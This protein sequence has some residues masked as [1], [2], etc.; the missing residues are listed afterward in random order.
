VS[1]QTGALQYSYRIKVPPGRNGVA[2]SLALTYSSQAPIYGGIAAG[3]SLPLGLI[4]DDTSRAW[5]PT[6]SPQYG[7]NPDD[8]RFVVNESRLVAVDEP[9]AADVYKTY[10][11]ANGDTSYTRYERLVAGAGA[12]WRAR[13]HDGSTTFYGEAY[14]PLTSLP[15]ASACSNVGDGYAPITRS[16]DPFGNEI[17]YRWESTISGE[18]RIME[19][20]W[21]QNANAAMNAFAKVAFSYDST[22]A[23][24]ASDLFIGGQVDYRSGKRIV[25]GASRL[26]SITAT[27][28]NP[29]TPSTPDHTRTITLGYSATPCNA[30]Y[31]PVRLLT[32]IQETAVGTD[33]PQVALPA[34]TFEYGDPTI[35][36]T[37]VEGSSPPWSD[38]PPPPPG[39]GL[40]RNNNLGWGYRRNSGD[41]RW[42]TVEVMMV[43]LDGDGLLDRLVNTSRPGP[44]ILG[45]DGTGNCSASWQ[46][47]LGPTAGS[48]STMPAFGPVLPISLPRLKWRGSAEPFPPAGAPLADTDEQGLNREGCS[49]NGQYTAYENSSYGTVCHDGNA[50]VTNSDPRN[51]GPFCYPG[52]TECPPGDGGGPLGAR[53]RTYLAYRWVDVDGDGLTDLVTAAHGD[54]DHFD[55]GNKLANQPAEEPFGP[56]P[57]CPGIEVDRCLQIDAVCAAQNRICTESGCTINWSGLNACIEAAPKSGCSELSKTLFVADAPETPSTPLWRQPYMRCEGLYPWFIYKNQGNG[58][59]ASAPEIKYQP[60][61][62]ESDSGDS[63]I[64]GPTITAQNHTLMDFDGDGILDAVVRPQPKNDEDD[65]N[66]FWWFVWLGDGTGGFAPKVHVFPTR[67]RP[68]NDISKTDSTAFGPSGYVTSTHGLLDFNGDGLADH[69]RRKAATDTTDVALNLGIELEVK[70]N[71]WFLPAEFGKVFL[72]ATRHPS[73][74]VFTTIVQP[75]P[76]PNPSSGQLITEGS[77]QTFR[78][79]IDVDHDGRV[80]LVRFDGPRP[81]VNF[82]IGGRF[83]SSTVDYP[84]Y[85]GSE[86]GLARQ[87][88]AVP[89]TPLVWELGSD[90]IDLDGDGIAESI[91]TSGG[92]QRKQRTPSAPPRLLKAI[93]NGRG[94][95]VSVGYHQMHDRPQSESVPA[96]VEQNPHQFWPDGRPKATPR[97]QWVVKSLSTIDDFA[98]TTSTTSYR[99]RNPRHGADDEGYF[100]FRGFEEVITTSPSLAKT[101]QRYAYD[102]DWSGRLE[103][104]LVSPAEAL[105]DVRSISKTKW[106][107]RTLFGGAV[108]TYHPTS[109]QQ[110]TCANGKTEPQCIESPAAYTRTESTLVDFPLTGQKLLTLETGSLLTKQRPEQ[111]AADGDRQTLKTFSVLANATTYRVRPLTVTKEHRI[112]GAMVM[113]AKSAQEWDPTLSAKL[114]VETWFDTNDLNRAKARFV[115][116][117]TTGNVIERWKPVQNA[118]GTTKTTLTY[119]ARKLFV[120]IEVNELGHQRDYYWEYGTGTKLHTEGPN[121][122]NCTTT[123]IKE[124]TKIRVDGLGRTIEFWESVTDTGTS[125]VLRLKE[126][127]SYVDSVV[128][129]TAPA[130]VT[131]KVRLTTLST[132]RTETKTELDGH[133][134]PIK[135]T[136]YVQGTAPADAITTWQYRNDGTL[137]Y[138]TVPN[139]AQNHAGVVT[140]SYG[141]DSLGRP[142][143]IRRPDATAAIDQSGVD[144]EYDG[145]TKTVTEYVGSAGGNRAQTK[146]VTDSFG[147]LVEVH[148][149]TSDSPLTF[150][151][152]NYSFGPD[153][154]VTTVLD[155]QGVTTQLVHDFAGRRTQ[156]NRHGRT[157]KYSYDKNGN[158]T[159]ELAPGS[160]SPPVTDPDYTTTIA[161]DDLD[162]P[163][164]KLVGQRGLSIADQALFAGRTETFIWDAISS[165]STANMRGR[166]RQWNTFA[167]N[168]VTPTITRKRLNDDQ[169]ADTRAEHVYNNLVGLSN[170]V[171]MTM[172]RNVAGMLTTTRYAESGVLGAMSTIQYSARGFPT[173]IDF[174]DHARGVSQTIGIQQRNVAGLV[175]TRTTALAT[176]NHF[177][178]AQWT[179][180]KLGRVVAQYVRKGLN[181]QVMVAGQELSYL[182]NDNVSGMT[183]TLGANTAEF[184]YGYDSRHQITSANEISGSDLLVSSY[185]YGTAGRFTSVSVA[186]PTP[187]F[188]S[189]V[190]PRN[191]NYQYADPDPERVTA[192]VDATTQLPYATYQYDAAGNQTSRCYGATVSPCAGESMEFVYD[193][194]DQLRR[195]TKKQAGVVV[196]SEEYWYDDTGQRITVLKRDANGTKSGRVQFLGEMEVHFDHSDVRT[197]ALL[198]LSLG[199]PI[200]RVRRTNTSTGLEYMFHGLANNTLASVT[201]AGVTTAAFSYTPFGEVVETVDFGGSL[202][203]DSHRRRFNDKYDDQLSDLRYYGF[204]YYDPTLIGWTQSDPMYSRAP[205]AAMTSIP[206]RANQYQLGADLLER[207]KPDRFR[208]V[209]FGDAFRMANRRV[210]FAA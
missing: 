36:L 97:T 209:G 112:S 88:K 205:D 106:T 62:L 146:T 20:T 6:R 102:T 117:M 148:E 57:T 77:T 19:I 78:R 130:S 72:P 103:Q 131:H 39:S 179:Y 23:C 16:L 28:F 118:A 136:E 210:A 37:N 170:T 190:K 11:I 113:F 158:L 105:S 89:S 31:A 96:I 167:P 52:G 171:F 122:H 132:P 142:T 34:V 185:Q 76:W 126:T 153:D 176:S 22:L 125:F 124:D 194:K 86:G 114:T 14:H 10:R 95:R 157:W 18:C 197:H 43:D 178:Q 165:T 177:A 65:D 137:Q 64:T 140:Y 81:L 155:P 163:T 93:N 143:S 191:V 74:E 41:D 84:G 182:G 79:P 2:P 47:N 68:F 80:D 71:G 139:P 110:W 202:G 173:Q 135:K 25:S 168:A 198:H 1:T 161:Y 67:D 55:I 53:F 27:A 184:A 91:T 200:A 186:Q 208:D 111:G 9:H 63:N 44:T 207:R 30:Q 193:G 15:L 169:G 120:A 24:G 26:L 51:P 164:S 54:I 75:N 50:C 42:P 119:D 21:G 58:V 121:C 107:G 189:E 196:G 183:H 160:P 100:A 82:N 3:W 104:T 145:L 13:S 147:R 29:S 33:S 98:A 180:D 204:R 195:A 162:R 116:D 172:T 73:P 129:P 181:A 203:A 32:S 159:S 175:T 101:V 152:T 192:L 150:A 70:A 123:P 154:R 127:T 138:V 90:L 45:G 99:Y 8:D 206:R 69:W 38:L 40:P 149:K 199:T 92:F 83:S 17:A 133:G 156:I 7:N 61:P 109:V 49:L 48:G 5:L 151:V 187:P 188:G 46:K 56:W 115:Y 141:F 4:R 66:W 174:N 144:I 35:A 12:R 108:T 60:I 134:R 87:V 94:A 85:P 201:S 166:L 59:F 128:V